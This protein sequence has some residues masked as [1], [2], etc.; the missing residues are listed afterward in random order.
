MESIKERRERLEAEEIEKKIHQAKFVK[1]KR[2]IRSD[3]TNSSYLAVTYAKELVTERPHLADMHGLS[4]SEVL[5]AY[6][7]VIEGHLNK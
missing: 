2:K 6:D 1:L 5:R 4:H 7:E 3:I